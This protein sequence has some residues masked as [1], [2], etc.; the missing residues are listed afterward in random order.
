M[1]LVTIVGVVVVYVKELSQR[2][3]TVRFL[4]GVWE[5]E[6]ERRGSEGG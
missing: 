3:E 6:R 1:L 4:S 5:D 2:A